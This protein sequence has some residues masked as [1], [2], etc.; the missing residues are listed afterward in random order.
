MTPLRHRPPYGIYSP[1]G[2]QAA[3]ERGLAPLLWATWGKDW[4]KFTTPARIAR[5]APA[6]LRPGD[7]ILLHDADFYSAKRS[8]ER[9][10]CALPLILT[11]LKSRGNRYRPDRLTRLPGARQGKR[12]QRVTRETAGV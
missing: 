1:D 12:L 4:R 11:E 9:T 10:A 8:H 6:G 3:R 7:V 5:R 2:L